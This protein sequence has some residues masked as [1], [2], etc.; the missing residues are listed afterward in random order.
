[1]GPHSAQIP[2]VPK[3]KGSFISKLSGYFSDKP[4]LSSFLIAACF[5]SLI[6]LFFRPHYQYA[7][8]VQVLLLLKGIGLVQSPSALNGREN[9]LL[10][11]L[12]RN[13]YTRFPGFQWYSALLVLTQF[14]SF[15]A[16]LA[17]FQWGPHRG[18]RTRLFL[19]AAAGLGAYF[20]G[21]LQWTM[22]SSLAGLGAFFLSA[23]LWREKERKPPFIA[24]LLVFLLVILGVQ[25]RYPSVGMIFLLSLPAVL[26]LMRDRTLTPVRKTLVWFLAA[27]ALVSC[28]LIGT[29]YRFYQREPGWVQFADFFDQHFE[30]HEA[31][32]PVYDDQS[33]PVFDSVGWTPNDLYLFQDWYFLDE[34]IYSVEKLKKLSS[35]FPRFGLDK[36]PGFTLVQKLS[37]DTTQI[38][39]FFFLV[40]IWLIPRGSTRAL[41]LSA[42]WTFLVLAFLMAYEKLPERVFLPALFFLVIL[43]VFYA[44]PKWKTAFPGHPKPVFPAWAA[45]GL[46]VLLLLFTA[47]FLQKEYFRNNRWVRCEEL[48]KTCMEGLHSKDDQLYAVSESA[49]PFEFNAAFDDFEMYRHV[50]VV[51]LT[52]FQRSPTTRAMM[53]RFG[54]KDLLKDMAD[55][56]KIFIVC[57]DEEADHYRTH[58]REKYSLETVFEIVY[59]CAF[60]KVYQV[61]KA[62]SAR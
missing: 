43:C 39:L 5:L 59:Q 36:N 1:M 33:K 37:F 18:F 17:A 45:A 7:D 32:Y 42:F 38:A 56:P 31:R 58:L 44:V 3:A 49:F 52:W 25:M 60:F 19:F 6:Y 13:L 35:Y 34:D 22:T 15:W 10:C 55:N 30:L 14:L 41:G 26:A 20:F 50:N 40:L 62:S 12:L 8:D 54:V 27:T 53:D 28:L 47:Y 29:N 61:H 48:M 57:S 11:T 4:F 51:P 16:M 23:A 46:A 21:N 2:V 24:Y 9:I